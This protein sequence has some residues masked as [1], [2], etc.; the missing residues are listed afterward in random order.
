MNSGYGFLSAEII[1]V[2][3]NSAAR[4]MVSVTMHR[5]RPARSHVP[6]SGAGREANV[7]LDVGV[8]STMPKRTSICELKTACL[9]QGR[10]ITTAWMNRK[11]SAAKTAVELERAS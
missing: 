5:S 10:T 2:V 6:A 9:S 4:A 7:L 1:P 3:T 11:S 8:L